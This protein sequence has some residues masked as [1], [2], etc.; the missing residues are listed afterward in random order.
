MVAIVQ[1]GPQKQCICNN[2]K[3]VLSYVYT[4][5]H[6]SLEVSDCTGTSRERVARIFCPA[7]GNTPRVPVNF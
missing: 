1:Q 3:S 6:F 5:M 4:D 2:C 7:C